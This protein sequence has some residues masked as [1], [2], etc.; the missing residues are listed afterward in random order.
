MTG[1]R[2]IV[3]SLVTASL[4]IAC[5]R[6]ASPAGSS[7]NASAPQGSA[8]SPAPTP[9]PAHL[10]GASVRVSVNGVEL[11]TGAVGRLDGSGPAMIVLT[12]PVAMDRAS[13][14]RFL[15]RSASVAWTS[16]RAVAVSLPATENNVSFKIPE[17]VSIDGGTVIDLF[18]VNLVL[19][20]SVVVSVRSPE[21]LLS[22]APSQTD[23]LR[24]LAGDDALAVSPDGGKVLLFPRGA[25]AS[26]GP[27]VFDVAARTTT[28][29]SGASGPFV[30]AA[31]VTNDRIALVGDRVWVREP[32]DA[33][34]RPVADLA[35]V[36]AI[37]GAAFSPLGS[38]VAIESTE[39][40]VIVDLR[41]GSTR[42]LAGQRDACTNGAGRLAWSRDELRLAAIQCDAPDAVPSVHITDVG[43]GRLIKALEGGLLGITALLTGDFAVR[44]ESG[45]TGEGAPQLTVV[46]G[47]D[48]TA[49]ARYLGL[50]PTLSPDGRYMLGWTCCAGEGFVITDLTVP[51]RSRTIAGSAVWLRDGH[52][53]VLTRSGGRAV[54]VP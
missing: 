30:T 44:R 25:A 5:G 29:L 31:W 47:F 45:Q 23:G 37:T 19:P 9:S 18:I 54:L 16:A 27:R 39:R 8:T 14:E 24:I 32:H 40:L 13:V 20:S 36:G 52:V 21:E 15:P 12:F 53:V 7:P 6:V 17:S 38:F 43:T 42:T 35:G 22:G 50:G 33:A 26:A 51:D 28:L 10:P 41:T 11:Q 49:K 3:A 48:G 2:S 1:S 4:V 46:Y 34:L